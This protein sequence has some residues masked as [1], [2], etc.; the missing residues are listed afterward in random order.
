MTMS[1]AMLGQGYPHARSHGGSP[2]ST[3]V[4]SPGRMSPLLNFYVLRAL[5]CRRTNPVHWTEFLD[6][7][8]NPVYGDK[9]PRDE[10]IGAFHL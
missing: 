8:M 6:H 5:T 10:Q 9:E 4:I 1:A 3:M 7:A 2:I